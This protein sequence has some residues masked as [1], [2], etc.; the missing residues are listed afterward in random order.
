M[1]CVVYDLSSGVYGWKII[2]GLEHQT[3]GVNV[4]ELRFVGDFDV[5]NFVGEFGGC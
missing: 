4:V 3:V 1:L 5:F 2:A